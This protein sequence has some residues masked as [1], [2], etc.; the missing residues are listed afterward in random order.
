[1]LLSV[2]HF[3]DPARTIIIGFLCLFTEILTWCVCRHCILP[4]GLYYGLQCMYRLDSSIFAGLLDLWLDGY[5]KVFLLHNF[6]LFYRKQLSSWF[7]MMFIKL[8][9]DNL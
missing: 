1:M 6:G 9:L 5:Q 3:G 7:R 2:K 4:R 8:M